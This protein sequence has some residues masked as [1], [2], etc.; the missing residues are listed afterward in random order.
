MIAG[1][2]VLTSAGGQKFGFDPGCLSIELLA[3]GGPGE[4]RRWEILHRPADLADW[5]TRT[6]LAAPAPLDP[7]DVRVRPADLVRI[8]HLRDTFWA[9]ASALA[10]HQRP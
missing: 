6:R 5:L 8:R 1:I 9:I 7:G 3:T 4:G 2:H 10:H